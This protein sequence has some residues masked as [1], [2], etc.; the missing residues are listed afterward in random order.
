MRLEPL[1]ETLTGKPQVAPEAVQLAPLARICSICSATDEATQRDGNVDFAG[2]PLI[3]H[4]VT[5]ELRYIKKREDVTRYF[6]SRGW[7]YRFH[8]GRHAMERML[9]RSCLNEV[10]FLQRDFDRK[11]AADSARPV[12]SYYNDL[13]E[14]E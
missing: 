12:D 4:S 10:S 2:R 13:C 9:C 6:T 8:L 7:R 14:G 1:R 3:E 11:K 5:T